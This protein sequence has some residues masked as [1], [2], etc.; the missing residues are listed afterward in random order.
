MSN[1]PSELRKLVRKLP[2]PIKKLLKMPITY[3]KRLSIWRKI[4]KE[5][6]FVSGNHGNSLRKSAILSPLTALYK[7]EKWQNPLLISDA[8]VE[9]VGIGLFDVRAHSDDLY[10]VIPTHEAAVLAAIRSNLS[11]NDI[12]VDAGANIG[13]YTVAASKIVGDGGSVIAIEMMPDTLYRLKRNVELNDLKNVSLVNRALSNVSGEFISASLPEEGLFGQA[14]I[15]NNKGTSFCNEVIVETDTLDNI[16]NSYSNIALMKMDLEGAES[17]AISGGSN[18]ISR[19]KSIIFESR[20]GDESIEPLLSD[21]GYS[22]TRLD[23]R[24]LIANRIY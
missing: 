13:I 17:L 2:A 1:E 4:L 15:L 16:L 6:R 20:I 11:E 22:I 5:V 12:F 9:A 8:I 21:L 18:I 14:S 19:I 24:N 10:H 23:G 3:H 7:L